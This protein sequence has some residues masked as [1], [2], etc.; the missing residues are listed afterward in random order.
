M[1]ETQTRLDV[2]QAITDRIVQSIEEGSA[3]RLRMPWNQA[4]SL[5]PADQ[6]RIR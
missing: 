6:H 3:G 4:G 1:K 2:H 5:R